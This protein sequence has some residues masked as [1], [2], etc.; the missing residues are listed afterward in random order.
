MIA[1]VKIK[2]FALHVRKE[3]YIVKSVR[4]VH[5]NDIQQFISVMC[6][7]KSIFVA[8]EIKTKQNKYTAI[9]LEENVV[10]MPYLCVCV[11]VKCGKL[12]YKSIDVLTY[13][14]SQILYIY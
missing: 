7:Y 13:Y 9:S 4:N 10:I 3:Y 1:K 8:C 2:R 5:S 6:S 11:P 14:I 12:L